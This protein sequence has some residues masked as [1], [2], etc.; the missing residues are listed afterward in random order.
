MAVGASSAEL[1]GLVLKRGLVLVG[2][3]LAL[4]IAGA[5]PVTRLLQQLLFEVEPLD[6][7]SYL[8]AGVFLSG[9]GLLACLV[10]ALRVTRVDLAEVLRPE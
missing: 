1:V 5:L 9:V 8:A 10:P 4:G 2:A 6:L 7:A 3:G